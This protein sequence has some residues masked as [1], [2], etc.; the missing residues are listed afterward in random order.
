MAEEVLDAN[1]AQ[2]RYWNTV[3]G[4]RWVAAPGFRERRN[5]ESTALLLARLGI[6]GGENVLEIGCG[7]GALTVP[8]AA[9]V[10]DHGRLVAVDI[11][12]PMLGVVRQRSR[13][14]GCRSAPNR[15]PARAR[16]TTLIR[17]RETAEQEGPDRCR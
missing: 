6:T 10:G 14:A 1:A 11:S 16:A 4:P 9:A 3:A 13:S 7:T 12:E 5:E 2:H 8:L 15:D 17:N